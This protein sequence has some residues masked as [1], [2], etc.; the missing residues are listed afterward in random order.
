MRS[1][2]VP[3]P[4]MSFEY[5][6]WMFTRISGLALFFLGG[7]GL[8]IAFVM[9][10]RELLDMPTLVR[11]TFFPNPNHVV[12]SNIPDVSQ[13]W[14]NAY[15]QTMQIVIAFFGIS[16][17]FNGLRVVIEDYIGNTIWQPMLRGLIFLVWLF[18]MI[19]AVFVILAS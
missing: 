17:G 9:G 16:H 18:F 5:I 7:V 1:R 13:G 11:W 8:V 19:M 10:G 2:T 6:M 12:N 3:Q 14:A 4:T 15:W